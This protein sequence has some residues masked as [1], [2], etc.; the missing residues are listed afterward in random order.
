ML[1]RQVRLLGAVLG[2]TNIIFIFDCQA[3][4]ISSELLSALPYYL[5]EVMRKMVLPITHV[6]KVVLSRLGKSGA[7]LGAAS[8]AVFQFFQDTAHAMEPG[9]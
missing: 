7:I 4:A 2:L 9:Q 3:I 1:L 6:E 8:Q 5:P